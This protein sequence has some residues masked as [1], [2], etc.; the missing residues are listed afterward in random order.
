MGGRNSLYPKRGGW[1]K[2]QFV[3]QKV[4]VESVCTRKGGGGRSSLYPV[5]VGG[6]SLFPKRREV[7]GAE[8]VCTP[9]WGG[10]WGWGGRR[11]SDSDSSTVLITD[12]TEAAET[13]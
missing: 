7:R 5:V 13:Y 11:S 12:V 1:G 4:G 6:S 8:A 9:K 3:P 10:G 2:K